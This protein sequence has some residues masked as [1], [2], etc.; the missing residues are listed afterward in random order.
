MLDYLHYG[1]RGRG[2]GGVLEGCWRWEGC[3]GG[4]GGQRA[5]LPPLR[6][7]GEGC[8]RG[9]GGGRG[10]RAALEAN[11]LDY[12]HYGG[13]GR[14]AG[15][16]LDGAGVGGRR[17]RPTCWTTSTTVG[18]GGVLEGCWRG[19]GWEGGAGGQR[20]GLPPLR[21]A[22]EGCWRGAG[23]GRGGRAALEANVL[24]Y[25]HY[26]G[27]GRGAGGVL[28]GCWRAGCVWRGGAAALR[29]SALDCG[30]GVA[31]IMHAARAERPPPAPAR[32][33]PPA[34]ARPRSARGARVLRDHDGEGLLKRPRQRGRGQVPQ[35]ARACDGGVFITPPPCIQ[36]RLPRIATHAARARGRACAAQVKVAS[37][38][39]QGAIA[40]V[41]HAE[42][43]LLQ[44]GW[45]PQA[46][47]RARAHARPRGGAGA[48]G[49]GCEG[50]RI[51]AAG[52]HY[53]PR[54]NAPPDRRPA[55][56]HGV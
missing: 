7:A 5:G 2:A 43:L 44:A 50:A 47:A 35:G 3:E 31:A 19:Q 45:R 9:A 37:K 4:A 51:G 8:W 20:A 26:G 41:K 48:W 12:L 56:L 42:E 25:L 6:W 22:G 27:R 53:T 55:A 10:G 11:V 14:G 29:G 52:A 32:P 15:G 33:P 21:W 1:G 39:Y 49:R 18:G 17:W 38:T 36:S 28:E 46:R 30:G 23:G 13:R 34:P 16:V 24:D 54:C 40:P